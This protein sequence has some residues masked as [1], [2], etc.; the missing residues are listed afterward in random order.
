MLEQ[1]PGR[2]KQGEA[3]TSLG[4]RRTLKAGGRFGLD[5]E[6]VGGTVRGAEQGS[7]LIGQHRGDGRW[8]RPEWTPGDQSGG[9]C[10]SLR[11][12]LEVAQTRVV[13]GMRAQQI[14]NGLGE[15]GWGREG[16]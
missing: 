8:G 16:A 10:T 12:G 15:S 13:T 9:H 11:E 4:L 3:E 6:K 1:H 7:E 14:Q 5:P 2:T